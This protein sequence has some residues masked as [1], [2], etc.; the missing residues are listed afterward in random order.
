MKSWSRIVRE[1]EEKVGILY[2]SII[3]TV[4]YWDFKTKTGAI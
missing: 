4:I 3:A 2:K 1:K